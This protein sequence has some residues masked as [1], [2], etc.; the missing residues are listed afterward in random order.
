MRLRILDR[1]LVGAFLR[2]FGLTA[3]SAPLLFI[4]ADLTGRLDVELARGMTAGDMLRWYQGQFPIYLIWAFPIAALVATLFT[5]QPL[6]RHGEIHAMLAS[7]IRIH[8]LFAPLLLGGAVASLLGLVLLETTPRL[9]RDASAGPRESGRGRA[10]R[11]A[12]AYLTDAGELLSVQ[13]L[14]VGAQGRMYDLV[15]RSASAKTAGAVQYIVA[16]EARWIEGRG[17]VLR[18]GQ[19]WNIAADGNPVWT[20]FAQ[21]S[22]PALTERPSDLLDAPQVDLAA[23]TFGD[24]GRLA[25][26]M[27][28]SGAS[29]AFPRTTQWERVTIPL[30]TLAII[31]FAAPLATRAGRGEGELG[32]AL[33][34]VLTILYLAVL[35]TAES[36]GF[37]GL[38]HPGL[39]ASLPALLFGA[40]GC[41]LLRRA[42]T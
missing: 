21:L 27:E 30:T 31:M 33:A 23:M 36:L 15:L 4:L 42:H 38:L 3:L 10:E 17:W 1:Y 8:R 6:A 41:F 24:L 19:L 39:A 32:L 25:E 14:E 16:K 34:L 22:H 37:A 20:S 12:F 40:G 7:G 29:T 2:I 18:D 5:L 28:R 9:A 35:R 26:R 13:R 11:V